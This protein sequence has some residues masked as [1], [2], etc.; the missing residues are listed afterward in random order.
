MIYRLYTRIAC[1]LML[2][3]FEDHEAS[4][5]RPS[6]YIMQGGLQNG[7]HD[8]DCLVVRKVH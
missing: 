1:G 2:G 4:Q 6:S 7:V 8:Y 5:G 3:S